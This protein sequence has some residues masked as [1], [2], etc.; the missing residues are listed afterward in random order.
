MNEVLELVNQIVETTDIGS[1]LTPMRRVWLQK[2]IPQNSKDN[3]LKRRFVDPVTLVCQ[4]TLNI[5]SPCQLVPSPQHENMILVHKKKKM[6]C[7]CL[8]IYILRVTKTRYFSFSS[9]IQ[10]TNLF[11]FK[12]KI[13]QDCHWK[14]TIYGCFCF[15]PCVFVCTLFSSS[16]Q[17]FCFKSQDAALPS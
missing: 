7:F 14:R 10:P 8:Y 2:M 5:F 17:I 12:N 4:Y 16:G 1:P 15:C 9:L 3:I 13:K 11:Y 6:A